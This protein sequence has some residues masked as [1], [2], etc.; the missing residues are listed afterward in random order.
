MKSGRIGFRWKRLGIGLMLSASTMGVMGAPLAA[1]GRPDEIS[2]AI[3]AQ[4]LA[5][6]LALFAQQAQVQLSV[7]AGL[8]AGLRSRGASGRMD[9]ARA[10]DH[11]LAGTEL[12]WQLSNGVLT[13][14]RRPV[15]SSGGTQAPV[16][17][18]ALRVEGDDAPRNVAATR[19]ERGHDAVFDADFSSGY[20]D[21]AEIER[22]KGVTTSDLL[23]G[24]VNV[25]SGDA[26]NSG[27]LDPSIRGIQG[28]GRVPVVIDGTEQALTVWRGYNG[29]SNRAY[30]DPSLISGLQVLRG[31]T[32]RGNIRSSTGGTVVI[33]TLDADDVLRPGRTFGLDVRLEGGNNATDPRLPTLLTG[34]DYRTV[35]GFP[36]NSPS[37]ALRDPSLLIVPR[38]RDD[39]HFFSLGDRAVR[40]AAALRIEGL[41]LFGAYA[42]RE[43]GNYFSGTSDPDYYRQTQLPSSN[44]N[45]IR[46]MALGFAPG[47]EVPNTSSDLESVLLK[48]TWHIADDQYLLVSL[49]DSVTRYGEIMPS[50]ILIDTGN[51]QW[52]LSKV[53]ARAY[54]AEYKWQP[55][56]RW[57]DL[58]ANLWATDTTSDTY[59][60]GGMPNFATF[61]QPILVDN[62][63][64][65][66]INNRYGLNAANTVRLGSTFDLTLSGNWQHEKLA[67]R[68]V[69][70][71]ARFQGWRQFPRAGRRE[72]FLVR[73][74]GEWRPASFLKLNAGVSY[75][76]YWAVD[77]FARSQIAKGNANLNSTVYRGY[78][79]FFNVKGTGADF[80][81]RY[82]RSLLTDVDPKE[83]DAL[84]AQLLP[85]YLANPYEVAFEEQGPTWSPDAQGRYA[86]NGNP[87]LNGAISQIAGNDGTCRLQSIVEVVPITAP[88]RSDHRWAPSL[89]A[90]VYADEQTRAYARY[91]ETWRFPS[92]FESTLGFS[93]SFNP[94]AQLQPEH[95]KLYEIGLVRDLRSLVHLNREDQRADIKLTFYRNH[96]SNVVERS[97]NLQFSNIREQTIAG[98]EAEA[99]IDTGGFY[100]QLGA[101]FMT[102]NQVCDESAAALA[103]KKNGSVPNCVKYGFPD[104]FLLTQATPEQSV[105]W[106]MG[107][108]FFDKRL[109]LGGRLTYYSRY[110]NPFFE[111]I[112]NLPRAQQIDVYSLNVPFS[113]GAIVTAD[114]YVRYNLNNRF[115]AEL[116]GTNLNDRYYADPL[117][118]SLMPAPGRTVRL[119]LT[120]RF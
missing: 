62:A 37:F 63:R 109:E 95:A 100:T 38:T 35:P 18:D 5:D 24:M 66:A 45:R 118:R 7:D 53:H 67:S 36:Q 111:K 33:N 116:V 50:R 48:A 55:E 85:E 104:G 61:A 72:E 102:T 60:S 77:D 70:D 58:K 117:T 107:G 51:A 120:G 44:L 64:A 17:T 97:T 6:A 46:R 101:A 34:R 57:I 52:P 56:S 9:R 79:S 103:D 113:W 11:L 23:S 105:N 14:R 69:Y 31:P 21:R 8:L 83:V 89:S 114:A 12:D 115:S 106:T 96:I 91:I 92:M 19:A 76:G 93:A 71:P 43:R 87:C 98:I 42:Y 110:N 59:N 54:N 90:T 81:K 3:P 28:P 49:R 27:A 20:K 4:P 25:L 73:L 39:N 80:A 112:A 99:R 15:R 26:R 30:V 94:L 29:A 86:R 82:W 119:S 68:D 10:L 22:Y 108:R 32:D 74:D 40:V 65:N 41:D 1:Q 16:I 2:L 78:N 75:A 13:L 47:D 88:R 84:I